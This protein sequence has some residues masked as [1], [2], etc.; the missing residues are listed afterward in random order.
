MLVWAQG[1]SGMSV[2]KIHKHHII[3]F[4]FP[5]IGSFML[6]LASYYL[7]ISNPP[8]TLA[9]T[10]YTVPNSI[11]DDC[12]SDATSALN[13]WF[14]SLGP[15]SIVNFPTNGC[16]LVSMAVGSTFYIQN[17][18]DLTI[19]GNGSTLK[20]TSY[21]GGN[22]I[23]SILSLKANNNITINNLI[24]DGP[25]SAGGPDNEGDYGIMVGSGPVGNNGVS[26]NNVTIENTDGDGLAVYPQLSTDKGV[27]TNVSFENGNLDNIGYHGVTLEGVYNFT[28]SHNTTNNIG[29]F[30]DLEVDAG[31]S[32]VA[33]CYGSNG[34]P[35]GAGEVNVTVTNNSFNNSYGGLWIESGQACVPA[36]NWNFS[37]N[38][39]NDTG[40]NGFM[41]GACGATV[42][43]DGLT[44]SNNISSGT[45]GAVYGGSL[46]SPPTSAAFYVG[47]ISNF[48][49][50]NN[51][52]VGGIGSPTYYANTVAVP[53][54]AL[55][56]S[57]NDTITNNMFNNMYA[58]YV[59][60][61]CGSGDNGPITNLL[62]CNNTYWLTQ[63]IENSDGVV[64]PADPKNDGACPVAPPP[65]ISSS[66]SGVTLPSSGSSNSP[67]VTSNHTVT[68]SLAKSSTSSSTGANNVGS[69]SKATMDS[70]S[71]TTTPNGP[72][73]NTNLPKAVNPSPVTNNDSASKKSWVSLVLS[74]LINFRHTNTGK[75]T[76]G[77][78]AAI[79]AIGFAL[80][81]RLIWTE[82]WRP[83]FFFGHIMNHATAGM[84][85]GSA[86]KPYNAL[87]STQSPTSLS[88]PSYKA[89]INNYPS[90]APPSPGTIFKPHS[91]DK[92]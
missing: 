18:S 19:N 88:T 28:F 79:T 5:V 87:S 6:G 84:G 36:K 74:G 75:I 10:D 12:S 29:N 57:S 17:S 11:P 81:S 23:Q 15:Q 30:M 2:N 46:G 77:S 90:Q 71:N 66:P 59:T 70:S 64:P 69:T 35:L 33:L 38:N 25:A 7:N 31:C 24:I 49:F 89:P 54:I 20:Q 47:N 92:E 55:C 32:N 82:R 9:A 83:R 4:I 62:A 34:I 44:I 73:V 80:G 8:I 27:N 45:S 76:L 50:S 41:Y 85:S 42:P 52:M 13:T 78:L 56:S 60:N 65:P 58:P 63:P 61:D 86:I 48:T 91:V 51:T 16:Y 14:S 40:L 39:L 72:S 3:S 21:A 67:S 43:N 1:I 37:N 53:A 26:F 68:T 22:E